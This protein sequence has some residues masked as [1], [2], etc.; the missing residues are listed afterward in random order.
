MSPKNFPM[1]PT[2]DPTQPEVRRKRKTQKPRA[3]PKGSI[4]PIVA[5]TPAQHRNREQ[6]SHEAT[7]RKRVVP[8]STPLPRAPPS[9]ERRAARPI[10]CIQKACLPNEQP[11]VS[12]LQSMIASRA[13]V[14]RHCT[15]TLIHISIS[16]WGMGPAWPASFPLG[17][18]LQ[19]PQERYSTHRSNCQSFLWDLA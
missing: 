12:S 4:P 8:R 19:L 11:S 9:W 10:C 16:G 5:A 15:V 18:R 13:W 17:W 6:S 2:K 14:Q 3:R 7:P 1:P